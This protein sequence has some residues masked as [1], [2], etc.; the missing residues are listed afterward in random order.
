VYL[1]RIS[2]ALDPIM[3]V[4]DPAFDY[5]DFEEYVKVIT[6]EAIQTGRETVDFL[7]EGVER[8]FLVL[9]DDGG[10]EYAAALKLPI[11]ADGDYKLLVA[12]VRHQFGESRGVR[13]FGGYRL[14]VGVNA[15]EILTGK[16]TSTGEE[17]ASP[18]FPFRRPVQEI[19]GTVTAQD[20]DVF[21][22][23]ELFDP[24][25]T[26]YA[27][28]EATS[29][30]L[31]PSLKLR[32]F[33]DKVVALDNV[34]GE[35]ESAHLQYTFKDEGR[36][37][38]LHLKGAGEGGAVSAGGFRLM[39]G[40]NAPEVLEGKA[41]PRGRPLVKKPIEVRV[42][43]QLDQITNVNQKSQNYGAVGN[44]FMQWVDPAFAFS[45][46][47]CKCSQKTLEAPQFDNFVKEKDLRWPRFVF[48]NQQGKRFAQEALFLLRPNGEVTYFERFSMT[49]QAPD[50]DFLKFP[51]DLQQFFIRM[52]CLEPQA[53]YVYKA[54][55]EL[56]R[57]GDQLGEE[58]WYI[59]HHDTQVT[60]FEAN[61]SKSMFSFRF[62]AKRHQSYY[63]F[64]IFVPLILIITVAWVSFFMKDY[65][66]RVDVSGG[67]LLVF[68]A[69]NFT[70][71]KDLPRL[72]YLTFLDSVLVAAFIITAFAVVFNVILKRMD[73]AGKSELVKSVDKWILW[74]YPVVYIVGVFLLIVHFY[75]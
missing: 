48:H 37:Y 70:L 30:E 6:R 42:A 58:E 23:L 61:E 57:V 3:A 19:T 72:G 68:I 40:K 21:F 28:V 41:K 54:D 66:K 14:S 59:T 39:V 29:G 74:G 13:S 65:G 7:A 16:A 12:G 47:V 35:Q 18:S 45:P 60:N 38:V 27:F 62:L 10:K 75:Y 11:P 36:N 52:V 5:H 1:E 43:V 49:L 15:P 33:G 71:G 22:F 26:L 4:A 9:D 46:D 50:F 69:F 55:P 2:G 20:N 34:S 32:D 51:F 24:G 8:F 53:L 64:R 73:A 25:Q 56:T 17:V 67:N 31:K 44:L 63:F